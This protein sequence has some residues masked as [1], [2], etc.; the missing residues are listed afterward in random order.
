M[1]G[2]HE[3]SLEHTGHSVTVIFRP[4]LQSREHWHN[5]SNCEFHGCTVSFVFGGRH[6]CR[7]CGLSLCIAHCKQRGQPGIDER[8]YLC[9]TCDARL[10]ASREV[11]SQAAEQSRKEVLDSISDFEDTSF[12]AAAGG[13]MSPSS[14]VS[15]DEGR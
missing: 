13:S 11:E 15:K 1:R 9:A 2:E 3:L 14:T 4:E 6:H 8:F 10:S 5:A 12:D 7:G